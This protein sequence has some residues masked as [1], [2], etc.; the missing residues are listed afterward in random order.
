M[1]LKNS[2]FPAIEDKKIIN[3]TVG[4]ILRVAVKEDP[5]KVA[6]VETDMDCQLGKQWT[7]EELLK[8]AEKVAYNLLNRFDS[9]DKIAVWS[10]NT[11]E[12]AILEFACALSGM[13]LVTIN[14]SYQANELRYVL[15]QSKSSALYL[16]KEYR[17]NPML[18]I[19]E[20]AT[21]D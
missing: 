7:Y 11:A 19:A 10:P 15:E 12:W 8:D 9:G 16:I 21:K 5:Q 1:V 2:F 4:D 17:G 18:K 3:L 13:V 6:L 20:E 14:P